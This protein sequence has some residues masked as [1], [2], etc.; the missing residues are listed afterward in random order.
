[1]NKYR[2]TLLADQTLGAKKNK[3]IDIEANGYVIEGSNV[4]SFFKTVGTGANKRDE[5][6][7]SFLEWSYVHIPR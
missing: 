1:M 5:K 7:F 4:L 6:I 3:H 2:V